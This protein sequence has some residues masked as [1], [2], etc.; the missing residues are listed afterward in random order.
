MALMDLC[1]LLNNP[2]SFN[3]TNKTKFFNIMAETH[4]F[5]IYYAKTNKLVLKSGKL[6][7]TPEN[8]KKSPNSIVII[9]AL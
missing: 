4:T 5:V 9:G 7:L 3:A 2:E 1:Y 8:S 6:K